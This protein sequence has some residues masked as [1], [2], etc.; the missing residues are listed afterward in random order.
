[1]RSLPSFAYSFAWSSSRAISRL[2]HTSCRKAHLPPQY[3]CCRCR[4]PYTPAHIHNARVLQHV[5][6]IAYSIVHDHLKPPLFSV[7]SP[8][9]RPHKAR[10]PAKAQTHI[11]PEPPEG[12]ILKS[13]HRNS[14]LLLL[15]LPPL[16]ATAG[17][18]LHSALCSIFYSVSLR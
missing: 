15:F 4:K 7:A 17:W 5:V 8:I 16:T 6:C 9:R 10:N 3:S 14:P 18:L 13:T 2:L 11:R 12:P 1:M